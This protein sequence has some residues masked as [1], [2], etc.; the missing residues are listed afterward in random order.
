MTSNGFA[1]KIVEV[2]MGVLA[3]IVIATSCYCVLY[4]ITLP[5]WFIGIVSLI[6]GYFFGERTGV[7]TIKNT[8]NGK[9]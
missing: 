2:V 5:D 7:I 3:V 9:V 1:V 6:V 4:S 8:E